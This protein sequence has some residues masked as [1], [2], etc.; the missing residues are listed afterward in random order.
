MART[1]ASN[2][3]R[4]EDIVAGRYR[5][6]QRL[7]GGS[8]GD[9][10]VA[11]HL[12]VG[13]RFALKVL[14]TDVASA[15]GIRELFEQE[16]QIAASIGGRHIVHVFDSGVDQPAGSPFFVMELLE[17]CDLQSYA[18]ARGPLPAPEVAAL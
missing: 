3:F 1:Q 10:Y 2:V 14:R 13:K 4:A 8:V 12:G 5:L 17:G 15:P 11:E 9:V 16:A 6:L 7:G 18:Q